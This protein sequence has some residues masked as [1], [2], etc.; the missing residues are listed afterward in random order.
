MGIPLVPGNHKNVHLINKSLERHVSA[1]FQHFINTVMC[2]CL[3]WIKMSWVTPTLFITLLFLQQ[4]THFLNKNYPFLVISHSDF[5]NQQPTL[6]SFFTWSL[7]KRNKEKKEGTMG[8]GRRK[9]RR[10]EGR[11]VAEWKEGRKQQAE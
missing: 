1:V 2:L 10:E 9:G 8:G 5:K 6:A 11:N 3:G 7:Q 4:N